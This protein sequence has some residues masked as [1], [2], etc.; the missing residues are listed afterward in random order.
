MANIIIMTHERSVSRWRLYQPKKNFVKSRKIFNISNADAFGTPSMER[1]PSPEHEE[2][3]R[4]GK[5]PAPSKARR[6]TE[7][8]DPAQS[9]GRRR[10]E[11]SK[12]GHQ[13]SQEISSNR[14]TPK[15][16]VKPSHRGCF[17]PLED[18]AQVPIAERSNVIFTTIFSSK[19]TKAEKIP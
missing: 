12:G 1:Y 10:T 4:Q 7:A 6:R 11:A 13:I 5:N 8:K 3:K 14:R 16:P 19:L 2:R 18:Q 9:K 15:N 17:S